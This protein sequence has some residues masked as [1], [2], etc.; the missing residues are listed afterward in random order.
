MRSFPPLT[1]AAP[2]AALVRAVQPAP[3]PAPAVVLM[4]VVE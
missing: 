3:G 2:S 4:R 1:A